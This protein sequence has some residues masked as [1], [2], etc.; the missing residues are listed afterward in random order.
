MKAL[1]SIHDLMPEKMERVES[2][3]DWL[4]EREVPPVTL[5]VVPGKPWQ[6]AQIDRLRELASLGHP[7]A[8]HGWHHHTQP[9]K[10]YHRLHA[11]L[12][13]RNVAEHLDLDSQGV[14]E[15]LKRSQNWFGDNDLPLPDFYVPPAWALGP[16]S[17]QDLAQAPYRIIETTRGLLHPNGNANSSKTSLLK[18]PLTGYEADTPLR[19]TLLR[20]WN[21][22]Q[23]KIAQSRDQTLRI[24]IHPNDLQLRVADQLEEQ[25]H[26]VTSYASYRTQHLR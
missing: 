10:L 3:L 4:K 6:L 18:L 11:A 12:L 16:I 9:R 5:L 21:A 23:A 8:A 17:K 26:A 7:L 19:E 1:V 14:L 25:I 15:L 2:I 20:R 24:S 13:S 22:S